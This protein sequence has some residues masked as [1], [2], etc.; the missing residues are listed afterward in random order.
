M[1]W[2]SIFLA[3]FRVR[4]AGWPAPAPAAGGGTRPKDFEWSLTLSP[5]RLPYDFSVWRKR[6]LAFQRCDRMSVQ[7]GIGTLMAN[8]GNRTLTRL[9]APPGCR[10]PIAS[11]LR[12]PAVPDPAPRRVRMRIDSVWRFNRLE[13]YGTPVQRRGKSIRPVYAR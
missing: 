6:P 12:P 7:L 4:E 1:T 2:L 8:C 3:D 13:D 5:I 9:A 11:A 10:A